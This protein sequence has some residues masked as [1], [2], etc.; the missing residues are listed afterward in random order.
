MQTRFGF[1]RVLGVTFAITLGV[2]LN[3]TLQPLR[4]SSQPW[5]PMPKQPSKTLSVLKYGFL[6]ES[7]CF[8]SEIWAHHVCHHYGPALGQHLL[9][10]LVRQRGGGRLTGRHDLHQRRL[11][12]GQSITLHLVD[13]P[14][15]DR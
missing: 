14:P 1:F 6:T 11:L 12:L 2:L 15:L 5:N 8:A 10:V 3:R 9:A 4:N 13:D 7:A